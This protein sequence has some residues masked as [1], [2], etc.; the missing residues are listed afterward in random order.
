M[1]HQGGYV[2]VDVDVDVDFDGTLLR[3]ENTMDY[4]VPKLEKRLSNPRLPQSFPMIYSHQASAGF[5][6]GWS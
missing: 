5:G 1:K 6:M 4:F 3:F 2:D